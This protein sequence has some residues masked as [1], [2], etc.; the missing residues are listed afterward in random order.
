[1]EGTFSPQVYFTW[2]GRRC[3][4]LRQQGIFLEKTFTP[5]KQIS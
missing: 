4:L 3:L 1:M 2:A 5:A